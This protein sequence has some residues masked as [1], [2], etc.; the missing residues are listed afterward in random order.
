MDMQRSELAEHAKHRD[1]YIAQISVL[2]ED[3]RR[4]ERN[5]KRSGMNLEYLKNIVVRVL[6][7]ALCC[8]TSFA[9]CLQCVTLCCACPR[10]CST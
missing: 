1:A 8:V 2:R 7:C 10:S 3:V 9:Y 6:R 5:D 4:L